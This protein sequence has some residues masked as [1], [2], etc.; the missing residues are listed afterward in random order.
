MI[1]SLIS[2]EN[3]YQNHTQML[4]L[5]RVYCSTCWHPR[6]DTFILKIQQLM[7]QYFQVGTRAPNLQLELSLQHQ[8]SWL[9]RMVAIELHLTTRKQQ[10]SHTQKLINLLLSDEK[11]AP[12]QIPVKKDVK[13]FRAVEEEVILLPSTAS[14]T[15]KKLSVILSKMDLSDVSTSS[16]ELSYFKEDQILHLIQQ[17]LARSE[18]F[19]MNIIDIKSLHRFINQEMMTAQIA[20]SQKPHVFEVRV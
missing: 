10:R 7:T 15:L 4:G 2:I 14:R 5:T 17:H 13:S 9:L 1:N 6:F 18:L 3:V 12:T 11:E 20:V 19:D 8:Q 16:L